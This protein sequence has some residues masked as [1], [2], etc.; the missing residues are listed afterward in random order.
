[1]KRHLNRRTISVGLAILLTFAVAGA[2]L[3]ALNYIPPTYDMD[4]TCTPPAWEVGK[5][6]ITNSHPSDTARGKFKCTDDQ[7]S[8]WGNWVA[9]SGQTVRRGCSTGYDLLTIEVYNDDAY[10]D[11]EY[12]SHDFVSNYCFP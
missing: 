5:V 10:V 8:W 1:M 9:G 3:A 11:D 2:V 4:V 6:D 7:G 12:I